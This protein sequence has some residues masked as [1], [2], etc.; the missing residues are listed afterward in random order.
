MAR[1]TNKK[2]IEAD[3][4][5]GEIAFVRS[6]IWNN[7][8]R[9]VAAIVT[10]ATTDAALLPDDAIALVSLTAFPPGSPSR[11]LRDVALYASAVD[12]K[13]LPAAWLKS[14]A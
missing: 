1:P 3:A 8:Q 4:L 5:L 10:D 7:G 6:S 12:E 2:T 11:M 14:K 9:K 13:T